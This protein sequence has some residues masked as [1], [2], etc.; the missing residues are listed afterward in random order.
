MPVPMSVHLLAVSYSSPVFNSVLVIAAT[1]IAALVLFHP[2]LVNSIDYRACV[3]PLAS[4]IGSG[5]LVLGP[6][7]KT[8]FGVY[9]ILVMAG[10]CLVAYALGGVIRF[11]I[12]R[13]AELKSRDQSPTLLTLRLERAASVALMLAYVV[14]ITYYLNLF[15]A[16]AVS[17]TPVD[18]PFYGRIVTSI[19]LGFVA[20]FGW[21]RGF[22]ALERIEEGTVGIKLTVIAGL[23]IGLIAY[24]VATVSGA[25][26]DYS[27]PDSLGWESVAI[28]LGLVI[29]A[30]GF[31]TSRYLGNE[32]DPQTR[33]H[34][35][36]FA[37][38]TSS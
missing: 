7:L 32:F 38:W 24:A 37:Q 5:F 20:I 29:T 19:V 28:A 17:L 10:L 27:R 25:G 22:K 14:S 11:N 9:A 23:V 13:Y 35:M 16:F 26:F 34:T 36:R 8:S 12:A 18:D 31:E 3:T 21:A 30:Q 15:G 33:I 1:A 6:I 4:I 2:R